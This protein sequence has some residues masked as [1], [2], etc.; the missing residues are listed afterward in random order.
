MNALNP[1]YTTAN[2]KPS[3]KLNWSLAFFCRKP[4]TGIDWLEELKAETKKDGVRILSYHPR[5]PKTEQFV[6]STKP[7][8]EPEKIL[9]SVKGRFQN[10]VRNKYPKAF[11]RNYFL[12]SIGSA[13]REV[14][15][16]YVSTQLNHHKMADSRVQDKLKKYQITYPE[17]DLSQLIQSSHGRYIYNLHLVFVNNGRWMEIREEHLEKVSNMLMNVAEKKGHRLS[18]SGILA[19][20]IHVALG[21]KINE[22]PGEVALSYLNNLAY[23]QGMKPIYQ[24]GYYA[25]TFGNYDF[26]AIEKDTGKEGRQ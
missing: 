6:V 2:C 17:V 18:S 26:G 21:C 5:D 12:H 1:I 13:N 11:Q 19:D 7:E 24:S 16:G 3:Y 15:E 22:A 9:W 23:A 4:I 10:I 8:V 20:H 25:G 14:T